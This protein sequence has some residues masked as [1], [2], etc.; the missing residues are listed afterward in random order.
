MEVLSQVE[1]TIKIKGISSIRKS[2]WGVT[3]IYVN[4]N[5]WVLAFDKK[6]C[7]NNNNNAKLQVKVQS[8]SG[9]FPQIKWVPLEHSLV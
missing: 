5:Q 2:S 8:L 3:V 6:I 4:V 7:K 1:Q 9:N